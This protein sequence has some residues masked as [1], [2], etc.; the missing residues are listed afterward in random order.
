MLARFVAAPRGKVGWLFGDAQI[1][2]GAV[3]W[4]LAG[5]AWL[6]GAQAQG[7]GAAGQR[8]LMLGRQ[9]QQR[10]A[11]L[12]AQADDASGRVTGDLDAGPVAVVS[13]PDAA[14]IDASAAGTASSITETNNSLRILSPRSKLFT[15][16]SS[17]RCAATR[18]FPKP[19]VKR[20][21]QIRFLHR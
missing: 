15:R 7:P 9:V 12:G 19:G 8:L 10:Q 3:G 5:G 13:A 2:M 1:D 4:Q 11:L 17:R 16:Q 21:G 18:H 14:L 20:C 6:I